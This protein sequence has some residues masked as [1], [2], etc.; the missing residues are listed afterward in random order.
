MDL[1]ICS[2]DLDAYIEE[3]EILNYSHPSISDK[4]KEIQ[5]KGKTKQ[6]WAE[7]A[8]EFVRDEIHHSFD[9]GSTIITIRA[10]DALE[11]K[12]GIC[13]AK[14]HLLAALL[15]GMGIP[16]GFCYQ[17]VTRK[18]TPESGYAIHGLN[19]IY[20][21]ET[22]TWFRVDPRGNKPGVNSEFS[23]SPEK[24]AYPIRTEMDEV[25]YLHVYSKPLEKVI[26]SMEESS[27]CRELFFKRPETV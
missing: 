3:T 23:I 9:T 16:T 20:F 21:E 12:E 25:D 22:N 7:L 5:Q 10:S 18:G 4:I 14:A 17:R 19:A 24:L 27:D 1:V 13:F 6:E 11:H 8:F 2:E 26:T 15:R